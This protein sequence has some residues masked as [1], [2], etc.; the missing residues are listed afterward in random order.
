VTW[1][2]LLGIGLGAAAGIGIAWALHRWA[3]YTD[4]TVV[5]VEGSIGY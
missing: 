2:H 3:E 5:E 4:A 1:K